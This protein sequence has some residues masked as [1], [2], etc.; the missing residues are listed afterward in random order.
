[1]TERGSRLGCGGG[2]TRTKICNFLEIEAHSEEGEEA[3]N[4]N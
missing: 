2:L 3:T 4:N 1:M